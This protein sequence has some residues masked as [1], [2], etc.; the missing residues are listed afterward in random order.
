[1]SHPM[2]GLRVLATVVWLTTSSCSALREI[3]RAEYA[4]R[5]ERR[6]VVVDTSEGLHYTFEFARFGSDTLTGYRR[7]DT[8][9]AFEEYDSLPIALESVAK[10]SARRVDWYRTGLIGGGALAAVVAVALAQ[11]KGSGSGGNTPPCT[12]EP[13][14]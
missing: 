13:C 1:M 5:A 4:A 9:G 11:R 14:P 2:R 12:E 6:N 8:E 10:L 3:P 7:R